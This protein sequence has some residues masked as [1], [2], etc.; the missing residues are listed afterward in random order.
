MAL[1]NLKSDLSDTKYNRKD[2]STERVKS[3]DSNYKKFRPD[4]GQLI[5]KDVGERYRNTNKDGGLFRGGL[6]L[7]SER[8]SEDARRIGKWSTTSQGKIFLLK[9]FFLQANQGDKRTRVYNPLSLY[10]S[11]PH[12]IS[13]ERHIDQGDGTVGGFISGLIGFGRRSKYEDS[14]RIRKQHISGSGNREAAK[15]FDVKS[16]GSRKLQV[17][18]DGASIN[19]Q[20]QLGKL[21]AN[22]DE[23]PKDFIKFRIRDAVNGKWL[24]FPALISGITDSSS[25][26]TTSIQ[27]IGRP[28]KVYVYG[29]TDRTIGFS[30]KVVA[31]RES[32][33]KKIWEKMNYLKGLVHPQY[34]EFKSDSGESVGLGTR[35]VAPIVYLTIGD[36]FVNTPG[37]FKSVN[38]TIPDN[39]TWELQD[40]KQFPHICDV[41][42]DFQ[43]IGKETPTMLSKNYEGEVGEKVITDREARAVATEEAKKAAEKKAKEQK[44]IGGT[45][46]EGKGTN[47]SDAVRGLEDAPV[48]PN[49]PGAI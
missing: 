12:N 41:A 47:P 4:D 6:A 24:I 27:Y 11:L 8:T 32:D 42:L 9:Q 28:D 1:I 44:A 14:K 46:P 37:F 36:M 20:G 5:Q 21:N 7:Q 48:L 33:T 3:A 40:G 49:I 39:T 43:Y 25:A 29:G 18:Y 35:P 23:L 17:S 22:G 10:A 13:Q 38:I 31:L 16:K 2:L 30:M 45:G 15:F 34:K 26:E 19:T